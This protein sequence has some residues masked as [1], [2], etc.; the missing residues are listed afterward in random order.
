MFPISGIDQKLI[1]ERRTQSTG[2]SGHQ[3]Y[4]RL[5]TSAGGM[6]AFSCVSAASRAST[7]GRVS[8]TG[9]VSVYP[10][11][12]VYPLATDVSVRRR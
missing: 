11:L 3:R 1:A 6:S 5:A 10:A 2:I 8:V 7:A 9:G 4:G 12:V